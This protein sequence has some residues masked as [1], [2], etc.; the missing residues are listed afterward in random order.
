MTEM[1]QLRIPAH[2]CLVCANLP[3]LIANTQTT[4]TSFK[5]VSSLEKKKICMANKEC[6]LLIVFENYSHQDM[7]EE[8][9]P[10]GPSN[11]GLSQERCSVNSSERIAVR[12]IDG[13]TWCLGTI[14]VLV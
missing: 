11:R 7:T 4:C 1:T 14:P 10:R 12:K 6:V 5:T 3:S 9:R 8:E 13:R 2:G